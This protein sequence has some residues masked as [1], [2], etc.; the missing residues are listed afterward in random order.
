M[1]KSR[2]A[3]TVALLLSIVIG[4]AVAASPEPIRRKPGDTHTDALDRALRAN[5]NKDIVLLGEDASH[6]GGATVQV[7]SRLLMRLVKECGFSAVMFE[8]AT[9]DFLAFERAVAEGKATSKKLADS[10]GGLW[11][12]RRESESL[13]DFLF[14][15]AVQKRVKILG[16]DAQLGGL[17]QTY[18]RNEL[19]ADLSGSL[20]EPRRSQCSAELH[21]LSA[22]RFD[23]THPFDETVRERLLSCLSDIE[24]RVQTPGGEPAGELSMF[25]VSNVATYVRHQGNTSWAWREQAMFDNLEWQW[26]RLPEGAKV[27]VWCATVHATKDGSLAGQGGESLG[28]RIRRKYGDRSAAI[29]ISALG[30]EIAPRGRARQVLPPLDADAIEVRVFAK[31][32]QRDLIYVDYQDLVEFGNAS[33][34]VL[35][36]MK[37]LRTHW[38]NALDGM[39]ILRN[40][41]PPEYIDLPGI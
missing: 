41:L 8:T 35:R 24:S 4:G 34:R 26:R 9:Y 28:S 14:A 15:E 37:P 29:G 39:I 23:A 7:K 19:A 12:Y 3:S 25:L 38:A 30:G 18:A 16:I 40:E 22:W 10:I 20:N 31:E 27:I 6:A 36:Y 32:P 13:F 5:C 17:T 33:A 11:A 2:A 1:D 21:R